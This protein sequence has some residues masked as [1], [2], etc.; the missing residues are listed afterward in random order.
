MTYLHDAPKDGP[1]KNVIQGLTQSAESHQEAIKC[2]K[3]RYDRPRLTH[4]EH[5]RSIVQAPPMKADNGR[6]LRRL[7]DL[8]NQH[9][10]AIKP[11]DAYDIDTFLTATI[12]LKLGET[13][14]LKWMEHSNDSTK[15]PPYTDLLKYMDLQAQHFESAPF[16][17]KQQTAA[18]KSYTAVEEACVACGKANHP[19]G[20]CV[21]FQSATREEHWDLVMSNARC[22]NCLKSGHIASKCRAPPMCKKCH[23]QHHTLLHKGAGTKLQGGKE[24]SS[25]SY[26]AS[27][28]ES[29]EV[30]LMT[31]R[32]KVTASDGSVTQARALLD[33]AASTSLVTER[34]VRRLRLPRRYSNFTINGVAGC[35]VRPKGTVSFKVAGVRGGGKQIEVE[36]SVLP[37]VTADL[38]TIPVSP[39]TQWKHLSGLELADPDYRTPARVDILLRGD[40][41]SK[42]VLHGRRLSP[43]GAPCAFKTCFGWVLNSETKGQSRHSSTHVCGVALDNDTLRRFW[44]IEDYHIQEPALSPVE[45][46]D[47]MRC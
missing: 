28:R 1:A 12:E 33:S 17:R 36:A 42:A 21:K 46:R 43:T 13:T 32:V 25:A 40:V 18:Y 23:K 26:T 22:R 35:S 15:T 7:Y 20:N 37:K 24:P 16:E 45:M 38:P 27:S 5:V 6:E 39:V 11:F 4:R 47:E 34:L 41:F 8:W 44:E 30:L 14:K 2:L 9:I 19:L 10:K 29:K 3:E 31:C